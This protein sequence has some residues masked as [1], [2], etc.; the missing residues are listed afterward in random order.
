[1]ITRFKP[2]SPAPPPDVAAPGRRQGDPGPAAE[3]AVDANLLFHSVLW[4]LEARAAAALPF[5]EERTSLLDD[6]CALRQWHAGQQ[7][8][9]R[10]AVLGQAALRQCQ[11]E[12]ATA[13]VALKGTHAGD[14]RQRHR[15]EHDAFTLLPNA[16]VFRSRIDGVLGDAPAG[17]LRL[18]VF[19]V[20]LNGFKPINDRYGHHVGDE[21]LRAVASRLRCA[22][23]AEDLVC[24]LGGDE[25]GCVLGADLDRG[26][27]Q[28]LA[29]E[30]FEAVSA[31]L[32]VGGRSVSVQPSIGIARCPDDARTTAELIQRAD[33]A[34]YAAK[35]RQV[36]YAFFES[37]GAA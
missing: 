19:Y 20:D 3:A 33:A 4:R 16:E 23:R 5:G 35:R 25:F 24:R 2:R 31:P 37:A 1:M 8:R 13:R 6:V 22:V 21:V 28:R 17:T 14:R 9:D 10:Q 27:L 36:G 26:P 29:R 18:A 12:L 15:A 7:L 34:M 11:T 30:L 32:S